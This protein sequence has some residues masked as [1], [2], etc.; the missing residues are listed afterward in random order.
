[1]VTSLVVPAVVMRFVAV[2]VKLRMPDSMLT[3]V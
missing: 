3:R 2:R 1:M